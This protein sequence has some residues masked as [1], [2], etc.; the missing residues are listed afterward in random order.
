MRLAARSAAEADLAER[1]AFLGACYCGQEEADVALDDGEDIVEV[2]RDTAGQ[3]AHRLHLHGL[4]QAFFEFLAL[5]D[6]HFHAEQLD[7]F[8]VLPQW[9]DGEVKGTLGPIWQA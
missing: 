8:P 6:I 5:R 7:G 4:P 2:M 3:V 1:F 9:E